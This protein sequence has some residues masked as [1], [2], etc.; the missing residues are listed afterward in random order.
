MSEQITLPVKLEPILQQVQSFV[1]IMMKGRDAAVAAMKNFTSV[2]NE[3]DLNNLNGLLVKVRA[4]YDKIYGMRTEIT[5]ELDACKEF[6]MQFEKDLDQ[7]GKNNE[8]AR[9]RNMIAA[10]NQKIID[11]NNRV[12]REAELQKQKENQK[13]DVTARIKKNLAD[14][15][16]QRA[17]EVQ[18]GS[19]KFF[20]ET[21]LETWD[22]RAKT[23]MTF[24]TSLKKETYEICFNVSYN[25]DYLTPDEF[26][27]L[28]EAIKVDEPYE[29][30][31]DEVNKVITPILNDWRGRMDDI[32][33]DKIKL[34]NASDA[35]RERIEKEQKEKAEHEEQV[36]KDQIAAMQKESDAR[37]EQEKQADKLQ[38][39]FREQ[40]VTQRLDD[41]GPVKLILK[42]KEDKPVKALTEIMYHCFM[43]PKF[44]EIIKKDKDKNFKFDEHGFPVYVD[45]VESLVSFFVKYCDVNIGGVE[46]KEIS[47]VIVRK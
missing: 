34:K 1:P 14:I 6:L 40:A 8:V 11:E 15:L 13:S 36:R 38:N 30:W 4:T 33:Q 35:E 41:A 17:S 9:C 37:I 19:K 5:K 21:T 18:S 7:S 46:I 44:P 3:Q 2:E 22:A 31:S 43:H 39:D 29:K 25:R 23:F 24:R 12:K 26:T 20:D 10:Y 28:C 27:Q 45:W 32:K 42:F 16:I 47:K